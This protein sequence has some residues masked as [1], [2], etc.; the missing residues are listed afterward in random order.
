M[1]TKDQKRKPGKPKAK[2]MFD[3]DVGTQLALAL[4]KEPKNPDCI[5]DFYSVM[6]PMVRRALETKFAK[7]I[8]SSTLDDLTQDI[9]LKLINKID[10]YDVHKAKLFNWATMVLRNT[11]IDYF[12]SAGRNVP[13]KLTK[14]L[15]AKPSKTTW[16]NVDAETLSDMRAFFPFYVSNRVFY[17]LFAALERYRFTP[18]DNLINA[19]GKIYKEAGIDHKRYGKLKEHAQFLVGLYRAWML[20]DAS[21]QHEKLQEAINDSE[22][23]GLLRLLQHYLPKKSLMILMHLTG[24]MK[25]RLPTPH[26]LIKQKP[27]SR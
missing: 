7:G 22:Q 27:K 15:P 11:A 4:Q 16:M 17:E 9:L 19:I 14:D 8:D 20:D 1:N 6:R 23:V 25:H 12:R 10:K 2:M 5:G 26:A 18:S 21:Y 3:N 13:S 24:G